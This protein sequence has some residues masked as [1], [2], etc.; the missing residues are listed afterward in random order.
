[1]KSML[2]RKMTEV[3]NKQKIQEDFVEKFKASRTQ[4]ISANK[5]TLSNKGIDQKTLITTDNFVN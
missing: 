2:Q 5:V 3:I 1:M 4:S